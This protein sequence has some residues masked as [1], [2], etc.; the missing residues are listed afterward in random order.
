MAIFRK[1]RVNV[2]GKMSECMP[3]QA[4]CPAGS[5]RAN[6]VTAS[7]DFLRGHVSHCLV[8]IAHAWYER[9][10][11]ISSSDL[12]AKQVPV[13]ENP[14]RR[15]PAKRV[16][17]VSGEVGPEAPANSTSEFPTVRLV[18]RHQEQRGQ[19]R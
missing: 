8:C 11:D 2:Q 19:R 17:T 13:F 16:V 12:E 5:R 4:V 6:C 14:P 15:V 10:S 9:K 18:S 1:I 3:L 7:R